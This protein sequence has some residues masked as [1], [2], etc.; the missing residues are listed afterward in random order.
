MTE[1]SVTLGGIPERIFVSVD[2]I[3]GRSTISFAP[4]A[5]G[6]PIVRDTDRQGALALALAHEIA[7]KYPGCAVVGPHFHTAPTKPRRMKR[8][9]K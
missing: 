7:A 5:A 6:V 8:G 2:E 1:P 9:P 3:S 4:A